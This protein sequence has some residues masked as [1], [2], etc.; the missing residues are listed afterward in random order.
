MMRFSH[1]KFTK[2]CHVEGAASSA[3]FFAC[4]ISNLELARY[5]WSYARRWGKSSPLVDE[6]SFGYKHFC[7]GPSYVSTYLT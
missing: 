2:M 1:I 7:I 4:S 3:S 5:R 6:Q